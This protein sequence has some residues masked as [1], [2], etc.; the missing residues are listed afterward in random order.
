MTYN[1]IWRWCLNACTGLLILTPIYFLTSENINVKDL[2]FAGLQDEQPRHT[3]DLPELPALDPGFMLK[4]DIVAQSSGSQIEQL[5]LS[6]A[7]TNSTKNIDLAESPFI[8]NYRDHHQ[9]IQQVPY[10]W[11]FEEPNDSDS[12]LEE[13]ELA[14]LVIDLG[15]ALEHELTP[16]TQFALELTTPRNRR[17]T[18]RHTTPSKFEPIMVLY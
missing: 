12:L 17:L 14:Q 5:I 10:T 15:A 2:V 6:I 8:I 7:T 3:I 11:H 9:R 16:N 13:R 4:S 18:I 1:R